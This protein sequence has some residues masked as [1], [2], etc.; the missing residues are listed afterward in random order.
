MSGFRLVCDWALHPLYTDVLVSN[1]GLVLSYKRGFWY[2]LKQSDNGSGYLRVGVG[3]E[4]VNYI[5]LLVAET[6]LPNPQGL[7]EVDHID[8]NKYNNYVGNL[9]WVTRLENVQRSW[10]TGLRANP[11]GRPVKIIETGITY[12]SQRGCARAIKGIQG[13]IAQCLLGNRRSHRGFTFEYADGEGSDD[14]RY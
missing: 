9:E 1:S 5:H 11:P 14:R 7:P 8:E 13:N 10:R 3:H 12:P 2:E 4:N 6:F